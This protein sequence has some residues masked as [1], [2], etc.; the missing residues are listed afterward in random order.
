MSASPPGANAYRFGRQRYRT[1][2][3]ARRSAENLAPFRPLE[4]AVHEAVQERS[5]HS[6]E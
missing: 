3:I 4:N 5:G 6:P 2:I 1:G